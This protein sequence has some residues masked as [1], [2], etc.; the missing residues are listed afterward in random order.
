M[1]NIQI[2][3]QKLLE[4]LQSGKVSRERNWVHLSEYRY[5]PLTCFSTDAPDLPSIFSMFH[6]YLRLTRYTLV[7]KLNFIF[8][9]L[10]PTSTVHV[11]KQIRMNIQQKRIIKQES[12]AV[13]NSQVYIN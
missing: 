5:E 13:L 4:M 11:S 1:H 12:A 6:L 7:V 8:A 3:K 2:L 10:D 9:L